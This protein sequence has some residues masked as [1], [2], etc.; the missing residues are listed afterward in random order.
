LK[1]FK[2]ERNVIR[3]ESKL[4]EE[5]ET[6]LDCDFQFTVEQKENTIECH[7]SY[8]LKQKGLKIIIE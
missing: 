5:L 3:L 4:Q 6:V 2:H 1:V 7:L 8:G